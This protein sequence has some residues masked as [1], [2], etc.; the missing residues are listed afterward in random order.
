MF[1]AEKLWEGCGG[2]ELADEHR[3]TIAGHACVMLLARDHDLFAEVESILVYPSTIQPPPQRPTHWQHTTPLGTPGPRIGESHH[4]GPV[5]LAWDAVLDT[6]AEPATRGNL[7]IHEFAHTIDDLD[8]ETDGTPPLPDRRTRRAWVA[9]F[10]P[11]FLAHRARA[12]RGEPSFLRDYATRNEAEYFAVATEAYFT[13]PAQLAA[14]LPEVHAALRAFY[15]YE[16]PAPA[17]IAVASS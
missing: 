4:R 13:Q 11:A 17:E 10:E 5:V 7:V 2:L 3:V 12:E 6:A 16:P 8:G 9:A 15:G 14:A 1:V